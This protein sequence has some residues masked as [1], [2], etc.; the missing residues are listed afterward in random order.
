MLLCFLLPVQGEAVSITLF[1]DDFN[2]NS[3][4][5][6]KWNLASAFSDGIGDYVHE[7][8]GKLIIAQ[9][10]TDDGG[11]VISAPIA[12]QGNGLITLSRRTLVHY[13]RSMPN[14]RG[15]HMVTDENGN[16]IAGFSHFQFD[17]RS[18]IG[19]GIV[20]SIEPASVLI[21]PVWDEWFEEVLTLDPVTGL[22]TYTANGNT[23]TYSGTP[24]DVTAIKLDFH[25]WGWQTGHYTYLDWVKVEQESTPCPTV[26]ISLDETVSGV[27]ESSCDSMNRSERYAKYYT[28]DMNE[29]SD[30]QIDLT[31]SSMDTYLFLMDSTGE[32]LASD[33]DGGTGLNSRINH[34]LEPGR[35]TIEA[36]TYNVETTGNFELVCKPMDQRYYVPV[37]KPDPAY[38]SGLGITN[39]SS[40]L[41]TNVTV[42]V[43]GQDGTVLAT[44]AKTIASR[45]Q[46]SFLVGTSLTSD[47]WIE[48][49]SNYKLAGLNFLGQYEGTTKN[50]YLADVPFIKTLSTSLIIPHVAQNE[51]WDTTVFLANPNGSAASVTLTYFDKSGTSS[52][53]YTVT[54]PANGSK[55]IPTSLISG[56]TSIRGGSVTIN[57]DQGLAAFAIYNNLK[58]GNYSNAGINAVDISD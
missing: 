9:N 44:D 20:T 13:N 54:I 40:T 5:M 52:T 17:Y 48:V 50:S 43:Y 28:L 8:D 42:T 58:T 30:V 38:W 22:I 47:G 56:S 1:E 10:T 15:T 14:F 4:D 53:P 11:R 12:L 25:S 29:G 34:Y 27:L 16:N 31:S 57:S 23:T 26:S 18:W 32:L 36:T 45:G 49:A 39:L 55:E 35:Y 6:K 33:D 51:K 21:A 24:F 19:F 41:S 7:T 37:F 2:D 3:R 46:D